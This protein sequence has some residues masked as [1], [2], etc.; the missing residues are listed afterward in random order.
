MGRTGAI[1]VP[2]LYIHGRKCHCFSQQEN[3]AALNVLAALLPHEPPQEMKQ[4]RRTFFSSARSISV[5]ALRS[6]HVLSARVPA[7]PFQLRSKP[8]STATGMKSRSEAC[9]SF[10]QSFPSTFRYTGLPDRC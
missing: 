4:S 6:H 7:D 9:V 1:M 2:G 10:D 8:V 5:Q 3:F